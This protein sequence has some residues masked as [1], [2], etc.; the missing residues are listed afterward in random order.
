[1][2]D[3]VGLVTIT[4]SPDYQNLSHKLGAMLEMAGDYFQ[5]KKRPFRRKNHSSYS[6]FGWQIRPRRVNNSDDY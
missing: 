5:I 3:R 6:P 1:L 4:V 2:T